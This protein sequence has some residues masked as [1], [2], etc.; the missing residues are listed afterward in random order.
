[1][2]AIVRKLEFGIKEGASIPLKFI[3]RKT[4]L[5]VNLD[6]KVIT[7]TVRAELDDPAIEVQKTSGAGIVHDVDQVTNPGLAVLTLLPA[8]L[9]LGAFEHVFDIW[10]DNEIWAKNSP[11][12]IFET[13]RKP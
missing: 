10:L 2:S 11:L 1:M 9:D 8:D 5:G 6:G 13:V 7:F 4:R 3:D 12:P